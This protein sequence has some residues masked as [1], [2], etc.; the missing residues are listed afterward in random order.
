MADT[1]AKSQSWLSL[2]WDSTETTKEER[3]LVFKLDGT[4]LIFASVGYFV[5]RM[6]EN[7]IINAFFAGMKED[8]NMYGNELVHA[9]SYFNAGYVLGQIPSTI[10]LTRK[11]PRLVMPTLVLAW[12]MATLAT[13]SVQ[14]VQT[15]YALRF[16]GYIP[17][18]D[19]ICALL[20]PVQLGY[21]RRD[22]IPACITSLAPGTLLG[23]WR[24]VPQLSWQWETPGSWCPA[25]CKRR[26]ITVWTVF[27]SWLA[28]GIALASSR[29]CFLF[30]R[31]WL[32]ILHAMI[33]LPIALFGFAFMPN[34]PW[35]TKPSFAFNT[36]D[37][38]LARARMNPTGRKENEPW[39]KAKVHR[40]LTGWHFWILPLGYA[41][42]IN[43]YVE[44]P[45][46]YWLK[47]FNIEP[48]PVPGKRFSVAEIQLLPVTAFYAL[49]T[50]LQACLSDG[51]AKGSRWPFIMGGAI[52][53]I[54]CNVTWLAM[55]LYSN[56]PA[57]FVYFYLMTFG[58]SA[59]P[60]ILN[61]MNEILREDN[62]L[63]ALCIAWANGVAFL[64]IAIV[65]N[66]VWKTADFPRA[67]T[68][69]YY[70]TVLQFLLLGWTALI[71]HLLRHDKRKAR[72]EQG[73]QRIL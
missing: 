65:P 17:P 59:G 56:I 51:P 27:G 9:K 6:D 21:Q 14:N 7:N 16:L 2:L 11:P 23:N 45:M 13:Y 43:G 30:L 31:R 35:S 5:K 72:E 26:S 57:H 24:N 10:L 62:E 39:T 18:S 42:F 25:S 12:G 32:M 63:R 67:A 3:R 44:T 61:W 55:P 4:L 36:Q 48:Y 47:S 22:F 29:L 34:L 15:L 68:G 71:L 52:W 33:T 54:V 50:F 40:I 46:Q 49:A 8:L 69:F 19:P 28:G 37:I 38:K 58:A 70:S 64:G 73:Y 60:L 20:T 1:P 41:S 53:T 66:F